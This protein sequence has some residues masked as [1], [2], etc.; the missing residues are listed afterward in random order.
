MQE[1]KYPEK[2]AIHSGFSLIEVVIGLLVGSL[3]LTSAHMIFGRY[4]QTSI[5][6]QDTLVSVREAM[7][8]LENIR[9]EVMMA[10]NVAS[11]TPVI[12]DLDDPV[13]L[14]KP[15][16]TLCLLGPHGTIRYEIATDS[17]GQMFLQKSVT[18]GTNTEKK[19]L[20]IGR[21]QSFSVFWI[22]QKQHNGPNMFTTKPLSIT[23]VLKGESKGIS[24]TELNIS[25]LITPQFTAYENSSWP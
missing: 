25:T 19:P 1:L 17:H 8:T 22:Q 23:L 11:P 10:K 15:G 18:L 24:A 13:D 12:S 7:L 20:D 6:G 5:K 14:S 21:V 9:K 16:N 3:L 4:V 2:R